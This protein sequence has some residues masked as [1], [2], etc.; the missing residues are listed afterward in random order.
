MVLETLVVPLGVAI[1]GG[2]GSAV[3]GA[4]KR[5]GDDG[6]D[7]DT[8]KFV[9]SIPKSLVGAVIALG[10]VGVSAGDIQVN[11]LFGFASMFAIGFSSN[12]ALSN[13]NVG[14]RHSKTA[15]V[16]SKTVG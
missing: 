1:L 7:F 8:R 10:L 15:K 2:L 13:L 6:E 3:L 14:A 5:V 16:S 9:M 4:Y 12:V 11:T